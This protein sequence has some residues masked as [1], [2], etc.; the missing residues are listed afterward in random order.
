MQE[1]VAAGKLQIGKVDR[2]TNV[3]DALTKHWDSKNHAMFAAMGLIE[4]A[5]DSA[6]YL[7]TLW[8]STRC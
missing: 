2:A 5:A 6:H 8:S 3:A 7:C 1:Q 4:A